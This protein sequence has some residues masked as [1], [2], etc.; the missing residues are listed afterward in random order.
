LIT[1]KLHIYTRTE[2]RR[3]VKTLAVKGATSWQSTRRTYRF[4]LSVNSVYFPVGVV[5]IVV[6]CHRCQVVSRVNT[7]VIQSVIVK[8]GPTCTRPMSNARRTGVHC[9]TEY[10]HTEC[11]ADVTIYST[12]DIC[13]WRYRYIVLLT[14][15]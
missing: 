11:A 9:Y 15:I 6:C 13:Y 8:L 5:V 4:S 12:I 2:D 14:S 7:I 3:K 10:R 1:Y